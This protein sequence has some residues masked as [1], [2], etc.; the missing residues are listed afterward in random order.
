MHVNPG[1]KL[2]SFAITILPE[3]S[4][5]SPLYAL[6]FSNPDF[7]KFL[8]SIFGNTWLRLKQ[9]LFCL[10][11][12]LC[13]SQEQIEKQISFDLSHDGQGYLIELSP[14]EVI[15]PGSKIYYSVLSSIVN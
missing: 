7:K 2:L 8:D 1:S 13:L 11:N 5:D 6:F 15:E 3:V 12:K 9:R 4:T 10:A 14:I